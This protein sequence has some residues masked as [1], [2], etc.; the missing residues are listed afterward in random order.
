MILKNISRAIREQN[1]F[2]VVLEFVIVIAGVVI[3][4]QIQA[5]AEDRAQAQRQSVLLDRLHHE[6]EENVGYYSFILDIYER[7]NA[8]RTEAIE[9]F[10][11]NDLA[12][13]DR[14]ALTE[15]ITS[16]GILPAVAPPRG[17]FDEIVSTGQASTIGD[18]ALR[19]AI[20][21]YWAD[22]EF[23][24]GQ[25]DYFR[26]VQMRTPHISDFDFYRA[27]Y[28]PDSERQIRRVVDLE[29]ASQSD[30]FLQYLLHA[31]N[32][33]RGMTDWWR[34]AQDRARQLCEQ[35]ARL[36]GQP[37]NPNAVDAAP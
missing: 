3:G 20:A 17:V 34:D 6:A 22:V 37:C 10:V 11:A 15:A 35:T 30:E 28:D 7:H 12:G 29:A 9:R 5:W 8:A 23:L 13:A 2:A 32:R 1:W 25:V 31:N 21:A 33:A 36:T 26:L 14:E 4:F 24:Q 19:E 18:T 16:I 27:E